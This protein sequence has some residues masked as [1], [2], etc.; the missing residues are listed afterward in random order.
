MVRVAE[1]ALHM[2]LLLV[3]TICVFRSIRSHRAFAAVRPTTA[4][5]TITTIPATQGIQTGNIAMGR[6]KIVSKNNTAIIASITGQRGS[7]R[8]NWAGS[9]T[10]ASMPLF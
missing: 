2:A 1:K 6:G 7:I 5:G 9:F 10:F 4:I 3:H 8:N